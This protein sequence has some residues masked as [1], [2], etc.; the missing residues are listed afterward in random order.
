MENSDF[1]IIIYFTILPNANISSDR[2]DVWLKMGA[3]Y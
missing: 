2:Y 1:T 3:V